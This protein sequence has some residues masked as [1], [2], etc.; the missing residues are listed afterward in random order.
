[1]FVVCANVEGNGVLVS[2]TEWKKV[3]VEIPFNTYMR[4][5]LKLKQINMYSEFTLPH[6]HV[7]SDVVELKWTESNEIVR[8][9]ATFVDTFLPIRVL[10]LR[11]VQPMDI[12]LAE[13]YTQAKYVDVE[14]RLS[15]SSNVSS[16]QHPDM[17]QFVFEADL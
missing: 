8:F 15:S 16:V 13:V 3:R 7:V 9:M 4:C 17:L 12:W 5:Q 11:C 1:M 14:Y 10:Q 2:S 6:P